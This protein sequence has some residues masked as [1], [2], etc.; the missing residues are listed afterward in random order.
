M[1]DTAADAELVAALGAAV[2]GEVRA[3]EPMSAHTTLRVGGPAVAMV[4]AESVDDLVAVAR[5]CADSDRPWLILGRGSNLLVADRGWPGVVV[6]L[7]PAFRG[8]AREGDAL[9]VGG[10]EPMPALAVRAEQ[11][12]LSGVAFG[13]AIPGTLGGAVRMNAG[14]HGGQLSDVLEWA[15]V[16]H[17]DRG[18]AHERLDAASLELGYR[19]SALPAGAV[20]LRARLAL[21]PAEVDALAADMSEMRRWR[22]AHQPL[23]EPSCGSVFANPA[24]DSAGRLIEAAGLR[25]YRVGGAQ[26]SERHANF[27][28]VT[29]G[30]PASDVHR[31]LRDVQRR[32][33]AVHGITLRPEV[34]VAG[35]D[36]GDGAAQPDAGDRG[37]AE[38]DP[39]GADPH[40]P[41]GEPPARPGWR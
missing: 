12:G 9:L 2:G 23:G 22:R 7:G 32:V 13:V 16:A 20:V 35:F 19:H 31:V 14:A 17:L 15:E 11:E 4:R 29:H 18:G 36:D 24:G 8:V 34:V 39:A 3:A 26:V 1:G 21:T 40:A 10:A 33:A 37:G 30:S 25:G 5:V 38:P 28:V 27:I 6:A 41:A